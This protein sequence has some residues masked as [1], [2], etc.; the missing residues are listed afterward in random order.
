MGCYFGHGS[1]VSRQG[2]HPLFAAFPGRA[3][4]ERKRQAK[5]LNG[6]T[7]ATSSSELHPRLHKRLGAG[8]RDAV[9]QQGPLS[10]LSSQE[11]GKSI[12]GSLNPLR[13]LGWGWERIS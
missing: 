8:E 2:Q 11:P 6:E 3:A 4:K 13:H 5:F 1:G 7:D 12:L 10:S 9:R